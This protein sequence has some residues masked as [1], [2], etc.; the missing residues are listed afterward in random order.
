[1]QFHGALTGVASYFLMT[2]LMG[3]SAQQ[4]LARSA[5]IGNA[6]AA[7]MIMFGHALPM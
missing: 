7:Y 5:L 3:Q 6:T 1:M 4:A 2:Q